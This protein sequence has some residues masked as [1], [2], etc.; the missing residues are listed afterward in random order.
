ML[1]PTR[2]LWHRRGRVS[3]TALLLL[4][5]LALLTQNSLPAHVHSDGE[6]GIY[7][8]ECP[9]AALATTQREGLV[10]SVS[11]AGWVAL[12]APIPVFAPASYTL[13]SPFD[14]AAPRAPPLA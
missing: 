1:G 10:P 2:R 4:C 6:P 14:L 3:L 12:V 9:L 11:V 13:D 5:A 7:N 8:S